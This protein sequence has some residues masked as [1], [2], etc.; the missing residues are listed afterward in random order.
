M[1]MIKKILLVSCVLVIES[2]RMCARVQAAL[3]TLHWPTSFAQ[4]DYQMEVRVSLDDQKK[5]SRF[6]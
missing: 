1:R 4:P 6:E 3:V 2:A 5:C